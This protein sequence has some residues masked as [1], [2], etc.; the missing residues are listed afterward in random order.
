[1]TLTKLSFNWVLPWHIFFDF[2]DVATSPLIKE[3]DISLRVLTCEVIAAL[4]LQLP[5]IEILGLSYDKLNRQASTYY[6]SGKQIASSM[7]EWRSIYK[8]AYG[9]AEFKEDMET[10][11]VSDW[12][13]GIL[14]IRCWP[15]WQTPKPKDVWRVIVANLPKVEM[16]NGMYREDFMS[17]EP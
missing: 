16:V 5:S 6:R 4:V 12:L 3:L 17:V 8:E 7:G 2:V 1:M 14:N 13:V 11:D 10:L 9:V 15:E